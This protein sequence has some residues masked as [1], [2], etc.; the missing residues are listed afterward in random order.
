MNENKEMLFKVMV[1][2][3]EILQNAIQRHNSFNNTDFEVV[4]V[5]EEIE[6]CFCK[7]KVTKYKIEDVFN[8]G[9]LLSAL[10]NKMRIKGEI[11][12]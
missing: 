6:G 9:Y 8:F 5:M 7:I 4:E 3:P 11:D 10:E 1:M 12:W 2:F